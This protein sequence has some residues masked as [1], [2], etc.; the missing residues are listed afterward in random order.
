MLKICCELKFPV[1]I[2]E[3]SDLVL[4]DLDILQCMKSNGVPVITGFSIITMQ[5][6]DTRRLFEP[7]APSV[8][9]R[10]SAMS[11]I[12]EAGILTGTAMMPVLPYIYDYK[13]N[14]EDVVARTK[15]CGGKF[16]LVGSLTMSSPQRE[17]YYA[18][19]KQYDPNLLERYD[20]LY[21]EGTA[22]APDID[23]TSG[24]GRLVEKLCEK[25]GVQ[26]RIPRPILEGPQSFNHRVGEILYDRAYRL[27]LSGI[28]GYREFA[29]RKAGWIV[30]EYP[31][32]L[33]ATWEQGGG[34]GLQTI[35]G[36]GPKL[37]AEIESAIK[38]VMSC[39]NP[40]YFF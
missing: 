32:N 25:H 35:K 14:L 30:D 26:D 27:T 15:E 33:L 17:W 5:D 18:K 21:H 22:Y 31:H 39:S 11:K 1:F 36:I 13:E 3:K 23:Y 2:L 34:N 29:L 6:D 28:S 4:R 8:E 24:L 7:G 16:V 12:A 37:A 9:Q 40:A 10:F 20:T 19:L 38:E